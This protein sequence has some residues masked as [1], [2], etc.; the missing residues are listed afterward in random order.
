VYTCTQET[1]SDV[2]NVGDEDEERGI[3]Y[4]GVVAT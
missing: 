2:R 4:R 1:N 3:I